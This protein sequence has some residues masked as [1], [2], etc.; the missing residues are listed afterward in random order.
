L[1]ARNIEMVSTLITQNSKATAAA[2]LEVSSSQ[3][4]AGR[5]VAMLL[6]SHY[7]YDPRPRRA[8]QALV[9]DGATVDLICLGEDGSPA[10]EDLGSVKVR[11]IPL[12]HERGGK[13]YYAYQYSAFILATAVILA[14]RTFQRRYDLVYVHN[15]PDIL[16]VSALIPKLFGA[17]VV[18]DLHDPMPEL[19]KTIFQ[20]NEDSA[21]VRLLKHVEKWS[22]ARANLVVTVSL[23]FKRIFA[24]RSC[25]AGKIAVVMNAPDSRIFPLRLLDDRHA[26]EHT[27]REK[28]VIMYHGSIVERNGLEVL[29]NAL[30][31]IKETVPSGELRIY[32]R[33]TP[34]LEHVMNIVRARDL[35]GRVHYHGPKILEDLVPEIESCD[36]GV[37][38]NQRNAFTDINTPT[39]I[40]EYLALGKPVVAP[41]TLGIT[42]YFDKD[43]LLFF[44]SGNA[45]DLAR[46]IEYAYAHPGEVQEIARK[47]QDV[48]LG[49]TWPKEKQTLVNRI[50]EILGPSA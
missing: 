2:E 39:R 10:Y 42:D 4:L 33:S 20:V 13:F 15:M 31:K 19:M 27:A 26:P 3:R 43:S 1:I 46:Q 12:K 44:E 18:L 9:D 34:F 28:F 37:I 21:S 35:Q 40:F 8:I 6:F 16:V 5:R 45:D 50:S 41:S 30:D 22:L 48:Y 25:P 14:W 29:V 11:R 17:R 38:P 36:L 24:S 49:H 32:G 23:T 7:P 47:A